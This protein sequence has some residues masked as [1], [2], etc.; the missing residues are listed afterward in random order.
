MR[1]PDVA[2]AALLGAALL[3]LVLAPLLRT[4]P[5]ADRAPEPDEPEETQRGVALAALREIEFDRET[6]KLSDADYQALKAQYTAEA[7]VALRAEAVADVETMVAARV[8]ALDHAAGAPRC[9]TCGLRP[10]PDAVFCSTCGRPLRAVHECAQ[11]RS[12][13]VP[14]GSF[15]ESCGARVAA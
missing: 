12:A 5:P 6:G 8:L 10:E 3:W 2:A 15:C 11:C 14:G 13:L 7:L 9:V 1:F 4:A